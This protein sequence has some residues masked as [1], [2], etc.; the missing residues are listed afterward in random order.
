M[1]RERSSSSRCRFGSSALRWPRRWGC[2]GCSGTAPSAGENRTCARCVGMICAPLQ[3]VALSVGP[4][5]P[6]A[7]TR[8]GWAKGTP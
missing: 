2:S 6:P 7:T 8:P 4:R 1:A 3:S 5:S